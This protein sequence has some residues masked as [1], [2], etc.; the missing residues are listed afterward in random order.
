MT[1]QNQKL[2]MI[3][4]VNECMRRWAN[5]GLPLWSI[6]GQIVVKKE[7]KGVISRKFLVC[8]I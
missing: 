7:K 8:S 2:R 6:Y 1:N 3:R 5:Y 4:S